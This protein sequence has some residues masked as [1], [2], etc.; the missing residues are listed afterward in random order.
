MR[1]RSILLGTLVSTVVLGAE[2][3]KYS[4]VANFYTGLNDVDLE[5]LHLTFRDVGFESAEPVLGFKIDL[6]SDGTSDHVLRGPCGNGVCTLRLIDGK[7]KMPIAW[8]V[9]RP[10]IVHSAKINGWCVLSTYRRLGAAE[11]I[12]STYVYDGRVYQQVSSITLH[13]QSVSDLVKE[14]ESVDSI[15]NPDNVR[16][17][18]NKSLQR[19]APP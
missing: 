13:D 5:A 14:L 12:F 16:T 17:A 15:G 18:P 7:T 8:L 3:S 4:L 6:N 9:G 1:L 11:G 2:S 19:A 10:V